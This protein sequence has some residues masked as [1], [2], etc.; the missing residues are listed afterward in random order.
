MLAAVAAIVL[1]ATIG[2]ATVG[3]AQAAEKAAPKTDASI[4]FANNGGIDDWRAENDRT[5]YVKGRT[6]R[7]WFKAELLSDC[8]GLNF[9][10]RIAFEPDASG[11]L[12]KFSAIV[13]EGRKCPF[14]SFEKVDGPP[15]KKD[16]EKKS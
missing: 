8:I 1:G 16:K 13:V 7:Q 14:T 11:S 2:T 4:P 5:L 12:T 15:A 10:D 3:T 6:D 9:A